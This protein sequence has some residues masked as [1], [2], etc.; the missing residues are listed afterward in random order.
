MSGQTDSSLFT[1]FLDRETDRCGFISAWLRA[2]DVPHSIVTLGD[3]KHIVVKYENSAY[4]PRFRM[5][6]LIAHYDRAPDTPG[7]N[8]NSAACF[9]LMALAERLLSFRQGA[10]S[11]NIRIIFT[12]G[13]EAAGTGGISGQG[14]FVLGTG[15][16]KLKRTDDDIYVF[17]ACGCGDTLILSTAGIPASAKKPVSGT[18]FSRIERLHERAAAL[19]VETSPENWVRLPTPYSDNAGFIAAGLPAQVITLL[20]GKK[21][22]PFFSRSN[23]GETEI[24]E[25]RK[26]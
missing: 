19:A 10:V 14:S 22:A 17:D 24:Q 25:K 18:L 26:Y 12:D 8:D 3:K 4:D 2:R 21:P 13:E 1:S 20:P 9:Q 16:K 15:L 7:A 6:T 11:H 5:K 23:Q